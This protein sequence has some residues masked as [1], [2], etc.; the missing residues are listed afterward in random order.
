MVIASLLFLAILL[1][2]SFRAVLGILI[3][4]LMPLLYVAC[5]SGVMK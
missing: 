2:E 5:V 3:L 1:S 4:W